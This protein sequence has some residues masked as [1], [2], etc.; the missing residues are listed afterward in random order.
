[1]RVEHHGDAGGNR[2]RHLLHHGIRRQ[3][4]VLGIATPQVR[5]LADI[6]IALRAAALG[7]R[8]R[9]PTPARLA[10][11]SPPPEP[12]RLAARSPSRPP[13]RAAAFR[14]ISSITPSGSWP[15]ITGYGV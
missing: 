9:L 15:G 14:P 2:R 7:T 6:R 11:H 4:H 1:E 10:S 13:Q 5:R 8:A 12:E 3:V